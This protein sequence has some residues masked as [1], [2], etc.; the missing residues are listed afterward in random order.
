MADLK[1]Y[2][3][4]QRLLQKLLPWARREVVKDGGYWQSKSALGEA[5]AS[6][7]TEAM[8]DALIIFEGEK[9]GW[10]AD[11]VFKDVPPGIPNC[12]GTPVGDPKATRAEAME[13]GKMLLIVALAQ[14][15]A[16]KT[17][18]A[19]PAFILNGWVISLRPELIVMVRETEGMMDRYATP[20]QASAQIEKKLDRMFPEGGF[21]AAAFNAWPL[22]K[23]IPL[24]SVLH[25]AVAAG[26]YTYPMRQPGPPGDSGKI[27]R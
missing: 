18:P 8:F 7:L 26:L 24:L 16:P 4:G 23:Q 2:R 22:E 10:G 14:A 17:I 15:A 25:R 19:P 12:I 5:V 6:V 11:L 21:D 9:G 20:L 1:A 3:E 27:G 13:D